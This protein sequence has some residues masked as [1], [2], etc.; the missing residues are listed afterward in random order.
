MIV[1]VVPVIN[2]DIPAT[3]ITLIASIA[4]LLSSP[5]VITNS[6]RVW[7][8]LEQVWFRKV[9]TE[10]HPSPSVKPTIH[11]GFSL[12]CWFS[13]PITFSV[14]PEYYP[15]STSVGFSDV[16]AFS[17]V[18]FIICSAHDERG[19]NT[20]LWQLAFH[21][22]TVIVTAAVHR[23]FNCRPLIL[24]SVTHAFNLPALGRFQPVYLSFRFCTD[25]CFC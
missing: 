9:L 3:K 15:K 7:N 5:W 8:P 18:F 14:W 2:I 23:G 4:L 25:L 19:L 22:R 24:R 6:Y 11:Q 17:Q 13:A 10:K 20:S 1:I 16:P 21:H 12:S